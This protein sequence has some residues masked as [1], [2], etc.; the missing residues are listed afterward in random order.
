MVLDIIKCPKVKENRKS[1]GFGKGKLIYN[2]MLGKNNF[3]AP[4]E[5]CNEFS[6]TFK[7]SVSASV[8]SSVLL[9]TPLSGRWA[10]LYFSLTACL[11][12]GFAIVSLPSLE[13]HI[14]FQAN[15]Q[16]RTES[17]TGAHTFSTSHGHNFNPYKSKQPETERR[18]ML[19]FIKL[20]ATFLQSCCDCVNRVINFKQPSN[21]FSTLCQS[22]CAVCKCTQSSLFNF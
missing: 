13:H 11:A 9:A 6:K 8:V 7:K 1:S 18:K 4:L 21:S 5:L 16:Q 15:K 10:L 19:I 12:R 2:N 20:T 14:W 3:G 22:I 17:N